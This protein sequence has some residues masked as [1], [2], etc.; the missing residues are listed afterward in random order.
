MIECDGEI[1]SGDYGTS[2]SW[3]IGSVSRRAGTKYLDLGSPWM[4]E[5]ASR[6]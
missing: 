5:L 2:I 1:H 4:I 6:N 3:E